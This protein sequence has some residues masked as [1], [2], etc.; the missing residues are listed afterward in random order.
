MISAF[1]SKV[2]AQNIDNVWTVSKNGGCSEM[3]RKPL[4]QG[5]Q[6]SSPWRRTQA[7]ILWTYEPWGRCFCFKFVVQK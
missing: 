4:N 1:C 5:V 7:S 2:C 3:P 6:G